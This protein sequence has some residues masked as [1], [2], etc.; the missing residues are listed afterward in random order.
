MAMNVYSSSCDTSF[1]RF[2]AN[3]SDGRRQIRPIHWLDRLIHTLYKAIV[4]L[5]R[6]RYVVVV[7]EELNFTRAAER[8]HM[9]HSLLSY[10]LRQLEDEPEGGERQQPSGARARKHDASREPCRAPPVPTPDILFE[11]D[12]T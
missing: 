10:Q 3:H 5:Q 6:L 4:N 11:R 7:T 2:P 9:A 12:N 1:R 8:L